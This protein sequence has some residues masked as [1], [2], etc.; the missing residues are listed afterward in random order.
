[1]TLS[2][3]GVAFALAGLFVA[4]WLPACGDNEAVPC[5]LSAGGAIVKQDSMG[6]CQPGP[7]CPTGQVMINISDPADM[8]PGTDVAGQVSYICCAPVVDSGSTVSNG[9]YGGDGGT[10]AKG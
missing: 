9:G 5:G 3:L 10:G 6:T 1:M 7:T 2:R 8:C 4:V